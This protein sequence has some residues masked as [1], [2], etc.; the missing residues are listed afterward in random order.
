MCDY[1]KETCETCNGTHKIHII[2][3][4]IIQFKPCPDCGGMPEEAKVERK[5]K[6]ERMMAEAQAKLAQMEQE[7]AV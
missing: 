4:S 7:E 2:E 6:L 3:G 1:C 5:R